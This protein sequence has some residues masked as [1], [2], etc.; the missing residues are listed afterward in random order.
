MA[1]NNIL[2]LLKDGETFE[3]EYHAQNG[4]EKMWMVSGLSC[5]VYK[6]FMQNNTRLGITLS[7]A[8]NIHA[9]YTFL[10]TCIFWFSTLLFRGYA[11]YPHR[12][13]TTINYI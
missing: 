6:K 11:R 5:V 13:I 10:C 1:K 3:S 12:T 2:P 8:R 4:V 7:Y 9:L